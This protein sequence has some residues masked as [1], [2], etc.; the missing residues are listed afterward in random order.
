MDLTP[1]SVAVKSVSESARRYE[2]A[3]AK[4]AA[5][6]FAQVKDLKALNALLIQSERKLTNE[7]GLPQR[8]W[9][10]H[11]LYAPGFYTGYGVKTVPGVRESL[12]QRLWKNTPGQ[13]KNAKDALHALASQ[14]DSAARIL[15]GR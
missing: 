13:I 4:A 3:F 11:Q 2:A 12:E 8:P 6:G 10:V 1:L 5:R 9:F 14:I 7:Q 15:E